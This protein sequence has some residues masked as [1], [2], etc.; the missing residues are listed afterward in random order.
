MQIV[1]VSIKTEDIK[2]KIIWFLKHL[3]NEG[4][5]I[6][7]QEDVNDLKLLIATRAEKSIPFSE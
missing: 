4:V 2:D 1:T 7:S 6:L 5:E 3:E